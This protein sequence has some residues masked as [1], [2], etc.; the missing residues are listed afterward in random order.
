MKPD[1]SKIWVGTSINGNLAQLICDKWKSFA[2]KIRFLRRLLNNWH[3]NW[4][5]FLRNNLSRRKLWIY[6]DSVEFCVL[7]NFI[8]GINIV[9]Q[10]MRPK[11]LPS[12]VI[13]VKPIDEFLRWNYIQHWVICGTL[14]LKSPISSFYNVLVPKN[15]LLTHYSYF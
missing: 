15:L 12:P 6:M 3:L 2:G 11:T 9:I 1:W 13:F 14:C 8:D 5:G 4:L 10:S 7:L